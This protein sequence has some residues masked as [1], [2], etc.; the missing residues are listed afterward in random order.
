MKTETV[1]YDWDDKTPKLGSTD[2]LIRKLFGDEALQQVKNREKI[3]AEETKAQPT[4][5][6][7]SAPSTPHAPTARP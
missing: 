7:R 1:C 4:P 3:L 5:S 6:P 2:D